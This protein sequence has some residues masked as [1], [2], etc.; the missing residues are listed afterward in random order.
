LP[1]VKEQKN[2]SFVRRK[3]ERKKQMLRKLYACVL[4][5]SLVWASVTITHAQQQTLGELV[6]QSY[7]E[8]LEQAKEVVFSTSAIEA[9]K[10]QLEKEKEAEQKRLEQEEKQLKQQLEQTKKQLEALNKQS[11]RDTAEMTAQ[12]KKLHCSILKLER[13]ITKKRTERNHGVPV[14]YEN[15]FAKLYLIQ[16]WPAKKKEI[17]KAIASERARERKFGDVEDIGFRSVG[18]GQEKDIK[19][20]EEAIRDIKSSNLMPPEIED[21]EIVAYVQ[22]LAETIAANSDLKVPVRVTLLNSKEINAFALPGGF[23]FV[24]SGLIEKAETESELVGVMAHELAHVAGRHGAKL[25]KRAM[26]Y[27]ILFQAIQLAAIILTGGVVS[28]GIA[29][30]LQYGFFGLALLLDLSLLGVSREYEA[31]ADQLG[32]QYA[33]KAGYDTRGFITFFDKLAQEKGYVKAA[34]FFRTHPPFI[35]RILATFSEITYLQQKESVKVDSS[36]FHSMK[37]RLAKVLEESKEKR[38]KDRP[39]LLKHENGCDDEPEP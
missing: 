32:V 38:D 28:I 34:S 23:L 8:L 36:E 37:V 10:K 39:T 12:R 30:A 29:Y 13:E 22:R 31:E 5:T 20:G 14:V 24:D 17:E 19:L 4:I 21:K 7:L 33:W 15:K 18:E 25:M 6:N 11:S 35:E 9:F 3:F 2:K 26:I 27:G 1:F 16:Q